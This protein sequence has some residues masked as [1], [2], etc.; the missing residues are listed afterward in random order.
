[1]KEELAR[2]ERIQGPGGVGGRVI[3]LSCMVLPMG[4]GMWVGGE[5]GGR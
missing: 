3:R 2:G 5:L 1:M 4:P